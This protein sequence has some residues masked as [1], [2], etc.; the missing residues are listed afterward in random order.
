MTTGQRIRTAREKAG[1][2]QKEL[3][4]K[5]GIPYQSIGQWENG[6]RNPKLE[7]MQRIATALGVHVLDLTGTG[8]PLDQEGNM[9]KTPGELL[10]NFLDTVLGEQRAKKICEDLAFVLAKHDLVQSPD[11]C[12]VL[13]LYMISVTD[14]WNSL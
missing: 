1:M 8:K 6:H 5:L 14:G 9:K 12:E 4:Q 10:G 13:F 11:I 7:T 3:A 2:T